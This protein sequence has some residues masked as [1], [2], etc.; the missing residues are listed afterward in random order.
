MSESFR[1]ALLP[2]VPALFSL[3]EAQID[4]MAR[5]GIRQ[6]TA[7][8]YLAFYP[9]SYL[10]ARQR[11]GVL[12]VLTDDASPVPAGAAVLLSMDSRWTDRAG[13][14][15]LYVHNLVSH[16]ACPG[17]GGRILA[18]A[19][20]MAI[21]SGRHFIRLDCSADNAALNAYYAAHGY[22]AAGTCQVGVYRGIRREKAL[23]PSK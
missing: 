21:R 6:W 10:E 11:E 1:Q 22:H 12:Y 16:P 17:A 13:D 7:D 19:E 5:Q 20:S 8:E 15:A 9:L 23:F 2:E 14:S 4:W 3:Y 18:A